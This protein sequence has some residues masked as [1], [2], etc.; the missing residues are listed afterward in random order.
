LDIRWL[1]L[2]SVSD[3]GRNNIE[4]EGY[5]DDPLDEL[6]TSLL[7]RICNSIGKS[8]LTLERYQ[9]FAGLRRL[10]CTVV[11]APTWMR[12]IQE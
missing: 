10:D 2:L 9:V 7:R 12:A 4:G 1:D 6:L 5:G 11:R 8:G 3:E